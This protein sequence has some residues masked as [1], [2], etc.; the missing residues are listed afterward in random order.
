MSLTAHQVPHTN[1][2]VAQRSMEN[3]MLWSPTNS[4]GCKVE[5][6]VDGQEFAVSSIAAID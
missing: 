1:N 5:P 2:Q 6:Q 4:T 3:G